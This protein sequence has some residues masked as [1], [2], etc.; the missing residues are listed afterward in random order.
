MDDERLIIL[1]LVQS[2]KI[3]AEEAV[4]LLDALGNAASADAVSTRDNAPAALLEADA[5]AGGAQAGDA[6]AGAPAAQAEAQEWAQTDAQSI[7]AQAQTAAAP[8]ASSAASGPDVMPFSAFAQRIEEAAQRIADKAPHMAAQI[9]EHMSELGEKIGA[10]ASELG[11]STANREKSAWAGLASLAGMFTGFGNGI[12]ISETI[13]G[14]LGEADVVTVGLETRNGSITVKTWQEPGYKVNIVK[15]VRAENAEEAQRLAADAVEVSQSRNELRVCANENNRVCAVSFTAYL[16]ADRRYDIAAESINGSVAIS[17]AQCTSCAAE[18]TNG[19]ISVNRVTAE[20]VTAEST[21]GGVRLEH[22]RAE[23]VRAETTNGGISWQGEAAG[24]RFETT[25]GSI[26]AQPEI[27]HTGTRSTYQVESCN[28][29]VSVDLNN[30]AHALVAFRAQTSHGRIS[31]P[32][33]ARISHKRDHH[34][35]H[36]LHGE[37]PGNADTHLELSVETAHGSITLARPEATEP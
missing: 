35:S 4:A 14:E 9:A 19:S 34:D 17:G 8:S 22:I 2:G 26:K 25:N 27:T 6:Q 24:A 1:K 32:G 30:A 10:K 12:E 5:Q 11:A 13:T 31:V 20:S 3:T 18:T 29:G 33:D 16:P 36:A 28:G 15:K 21:N 37:L 23:H 7:G